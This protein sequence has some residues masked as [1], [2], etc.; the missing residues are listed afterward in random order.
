MLN[1]RTDAAQVPVSTLG[2]IFNTIFFP[3]KSASDLSERSPAVNLKSGACSPT[4]GKLPFVFTGL[5]LKVIVAIK[6]VR[7]IFSFLALKGTSK[8]NI[9]Q[10]LLILAKHLLC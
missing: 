7:L 5:P 8:K 6:Y 2:K 4:C 3:L 1:A 9:T 10:H